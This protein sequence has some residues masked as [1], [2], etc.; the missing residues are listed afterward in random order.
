MSEKRERKV[1]DER[2][3]CWYCEKYL[4]GCSWSDERKPVKGWD[5][6]RTFRVQQ[7][8]TDGGYKFLKVPYSYA[9]KSCPEYVLERVKCYPGTKVPLG[10]DFNNQKDVSEGKRFYGYSDA[11]IETV[12]R[13]RTTHKPKRPY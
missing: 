11:D 1:Y 12:L 13:R 5:A 9:I 6:R 8:W 4:T 3:P 2:Q 10:M 7:I